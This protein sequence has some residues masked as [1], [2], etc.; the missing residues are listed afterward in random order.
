MIKTLVVGLA[1]SLAL[2]TAAPLASSAA[3]QGLQHA[4]FMR[5]QIVDA[6]ADSLIVCVGKEDGAQAGQILDV[7]RVSPNP[8]PRTQTFR[9]ER[10]GQVRIEHVVDAHFAHATL[11][12]GSA[13]RH[14]LVELRRMPK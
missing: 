4:F 9:R 14:D 6:S 12:S 13:E 7:V 11:V 10:V 8:G 3:A 1:S 2:V 5:G